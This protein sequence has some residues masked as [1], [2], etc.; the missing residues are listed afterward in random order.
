[1]KQ[2]KQIRELKEASGRSITIDWDFGD[3]REYAPDWQDQGVYLDD[4]NQRKM[5]IEVSG[6]EKDLLKWLTDD[7]GM[8]KKEAQNVIRKGK[9]I[10]L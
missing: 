4:W 7:Y 6:A 3:P 9:R 8:D 5:E 10:K 2:F 1:M